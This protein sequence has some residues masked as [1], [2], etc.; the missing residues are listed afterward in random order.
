MTSNKDKEFDLF[1]TDLNGNLR[2]KRLPANA[3]AKVFEEGV[4]LPRSVLGFDF[5]GDDVLDN[6]LVFEPVIWMV[7]VCR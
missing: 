6:G 3:V 5:W 7:S 2:G 1:I 4:K